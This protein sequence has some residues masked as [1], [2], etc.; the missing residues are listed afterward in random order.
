[1]EFRSKLEDLMPAEE[2][3][4]E[5]T[6]GFGPYKRFLEHATEV[7]QHKGITS[8]MVVHLHSHK[9]NDAEMAKTLRCNKRNIIYWRRKL[10]LEPNTNR[11]AQNGKNN[12]VFR[13]IANG[14]WKDPAKR[15]DVIEKLSKMR[16]GD[17]NPNWKGGKQIYTHKRLIRR[18]GG[19]EHCQLCLRRNCRLST[20]HK[21]DNPRNNSPLNLLIVC[22][23]CHAK[24]HNWGKNGFKE[25]NKLWKRRK[26]VRN[27]WSLRVN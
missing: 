13:A 12:Q 5:P 23:K 21:N 14:N 22:M 11:G 27:R 18:L 1:V 16:L 7:G 2:L 3:I 9:L 26:V 8:D 6:L 4:F 20:H 24:F 10:G 25:G 15:V 17:K 19:Y